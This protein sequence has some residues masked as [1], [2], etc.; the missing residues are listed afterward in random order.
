MIYLIASDERKHSIAQQ[1]ARYGFGV[2]NFASIKDAASTLEFAS[3]SAIVMPLPNPETT[4]IETII[5]I[6]GNRTSFIPFIFLGKGDSMSDR[7][8]AVRLGGRAYFVD[9][10]EVEDLVEGIETFSQENHSAPY[11]VMIV[12]ND[13]RIAEEQFKILTNAGMIVN[14][15]LEA[16]QSIERMREFRPEILLVDL[17]FPYVMGTELA[18]AIRQEGLFKDLPILFN[19][20]ESHAGLELAAL[21]RGGDGFLLRPMNAEHL[22]LSI[23]SRIERIRLVEKAAIRDSLT[24]LFSYPFMLRTLEKMCNAAEVNSGSFLFIIVDIDKFKVVNDQYGHAVGDKVIKSLGRLLKQRLNSVD[25]IGKISGEEFC[26]II[27]G[28]DIMTAARVFNEIRI[29]FSY[30]EH[31]TGQEQFKCTFS[32]GIASFPKY[33]SPT[34]LIGAANKAIDHSKSKGGNRIV[35]F[36]SEH[37]KT[38]DTAQ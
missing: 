23:S 37:P 2:R 25:T 26:V 5:Q 12:Q 8:T 17:Y 9:P 30:L 34:K 35:S 19:A 33:N 10:F 32:C 38:E 11:R 16:E 1:I 7:L 28:M 20:S 15:T 3:P 29:D 24:G 14:T 4:D 22:I 13:P 27:R 36:K 6:Q 18:A 31:T 21:R